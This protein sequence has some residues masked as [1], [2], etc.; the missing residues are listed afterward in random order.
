VGKAIK[1]GMVHHPVISLTP[2]EEGQA[3]NFAPLHAR[4]H[5][6]VQ[7]EEGI[8]GTAPAAESVLVIIKL[9]MRAHA[10]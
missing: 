7:S 1:K 6:S 2:V 10:L 4:L 8:G 9:N 3:R 5:S